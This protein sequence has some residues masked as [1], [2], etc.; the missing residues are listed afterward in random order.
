MRKIIWLGIDWV[1][2]LQFYL[3]I[4]GVMF[5]VALFF[6]AISAL[7]NAET[8]NLNYSECQ[9]DNMSNN[10]YCAVVW[11]DL[12]ITDIRMNL[13]INGTAPFTY[14]N[15]TWNLTVGVAAPPDSPSA[16][17]RLNLSLIGTAPY[18]YTN[19]PANVSIYIAAP[20]YNIDTVLGFGTNF[21]HNET[22]ISCSAPKFPALNTQ[23]NI[24]TNMTYT[25]LDVR[26]NFS[27]IAQFE[28]NSSQCRD[29]IDQTLDFGAD[30]Y[31]DKCNIH[32]RAP[33]FPTINE[34]R[35][36]Q[37]GE[38]VQNAQWAYSY[39][40]NDT[41]PQIMMCVATQILLNDTIRQYQENETTLRNEIVGLNTTIAQKDSLL[42][43]R[44]ENVS[45]STALLTA[46]NIGSEW[47]DKL[48]MAFGIIVGTIA[49][50]V[51]LQHW[52]TKKRGP[53]SG[54]T[55]EPI[56]VEVNR[57]VEEKFEKKIKNV[58]D[59]KLAAEKAAKAKELREEAERKQKEAEEL[60]KGTKKPKIDFFGHTI[61]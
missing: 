18:F 31:S 33:A 51:Y 8:I 58:E 32:I 60:E 36:L 13:T 38:T 2:L 17:C 61:G 44:E 55:E 53:P 50:L 24:S 29:N 7:V 35:L 52:Y 20:I 54:A 43:D 21:T 39:M 3:I 23:L 49:G 26:Y 4:M 30:Y 28:Y 22:N 12:N 16:D 15:S 11:Q 41:S 56:M 14:T 40:C 1:W 45:V 48:V 25:P 46:N 5:T 10:T 47:V 37:P 42:R 9:T 6:A 59:A 19:L 34:T 27:V 57:I